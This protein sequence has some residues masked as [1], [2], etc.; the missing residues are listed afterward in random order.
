M[1]ATPGQMPPGRHLPPILAKVICPMPP[2]GRKQQCYANSMELMDDLRK[3]TRLRDEL[4]FVGFEQAHG[5]GMHF[6]VEDAISVYDRTNMIPE[7]PRVTRVAKRTFW[8]DCGR[9][10]EGK[11]IVRLTVEQYDVHNAIMYA[12]SDCGVEGCKSFHRM[13]TQMKLIVALWDQGGAHETWVERLYRIARR[14]CPR[15]GDV[16]VVKTALVNAFAV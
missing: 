16:G 6:V 2:P 12:L 4:R 13:F 3:D 15:G 5:Y 1:Q 10:S 7:H 11:H 8:E 14:L 9:V